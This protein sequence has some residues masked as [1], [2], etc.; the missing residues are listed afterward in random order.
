MKLHLFAAAVALS[1]AAP[2]QE[3]EPDNEGCKDSKLLT[4]MP[5]CRIS[6]CVAKDFDSAE[7][8]VGR[9]GEDWLTKPLEGKI[10]VLDYECAQNVSPLNVARNIEGALRKSGYKIVFSGKGPSDEP[11]VSGHNGAQW[12]QVRAWVN[13]DI[14]CYTQTTVLVQEMAQTV[15][16]SADAWAAEI[17]KSGRVAVYGITFDTGKAAIKPD[18]EPVLNEI[19]A[20]LNK[21][22]DWKLRIEGHTDNVGPKAAN[23]ALS[24]QRAESVAAWLAAHGIEKARL[25]PQ[26]FG[27][28]KPVADNAA[29]EGRARN[30]RVE[31]VKM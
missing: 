2:A 27:D 7:F 31:L 26:G 29:E 15:E 22:P 28:A 12:V 18:S 8:L 3:L 25:L 4:R 13:G 20:L 17:E 10:E 21:Q 30:R 14:P 23:Q 1:F 11:T 9:A 16:A 19:V 6:E 5:R 24:Q